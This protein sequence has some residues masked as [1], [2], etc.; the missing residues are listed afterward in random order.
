[1]APSQT[2]YAFINQQDTLLKGKLPS[3]YEFVP[4]TPLI[5]PGIEVEPLIT[6][7]TL[8]ATPRILEAPSSSFSMAPTPRREEIAKQLSSKAAKQMKARQLR[9][10]GPSNLSSASD[11]IDKTPALKILRSNLSAS[12]NSTHFSSR[13][14]KSKEN[15]EFTGIL[16][17]NSLF[18]PSRT[19]GRTPRLLA[20]RDPW[21]TPTPRT[22][23]FTPILSKKNK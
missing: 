21:H 22:A 17:S 16:T 13:T 19:P 9:S 2:P 14:Q 20:A 15:A 6:W 4:S 8:A 5:R 23:S 18:T 1:M 7:G 11:K 3:Q 10:A 12:R